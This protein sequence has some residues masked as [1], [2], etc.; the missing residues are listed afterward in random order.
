MID[1]NAYRIACKLEKA[2]VFAISMKY[3]K[4]QAKKKARPET[5]PKNVIPKI[6]HDFLDVF[7]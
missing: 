6:Y 1:A 5:N 4:F 7:S 3:L 2:Q